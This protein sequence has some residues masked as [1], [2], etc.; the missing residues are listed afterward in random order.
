MPYE[1]AGPQWEE[2]DV[3]MEAEIG[4]ILPSARE[5]LGPLEG[6]GGARGSV[7][8]LTVG[9]PNSSSPELRIHFCFNLLW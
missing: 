3:E 6:Q 7:A 8:L 1:G 9:I 2:G 5:I 4:G